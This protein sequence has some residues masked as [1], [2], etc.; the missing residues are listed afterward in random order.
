MLILRIGNIT[1]VK[2]QTKDKFQSKWL[3]TYLSL[4][5]LIY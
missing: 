2:Q 1:K 4:K 3:I 5:L